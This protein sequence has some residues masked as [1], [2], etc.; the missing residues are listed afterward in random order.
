MTSSDWFEPPMA[1]AADAVVELLS[2]R[3]ND[4]ALA[5]AQLAR[6]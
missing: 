1:A 3:R 5:K 4:A 6:A 2:I